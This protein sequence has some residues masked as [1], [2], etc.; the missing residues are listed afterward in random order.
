MLRG[1]G[2][3]HLDIVCDKLR[4]AYGVEVETGQAY[5]AYRYVSSFPF[6]IVFFLC[7]LMWDSCKHTQGKYQ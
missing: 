1:V 5:V 7:H 4:R 6:Q 2:E 3:L